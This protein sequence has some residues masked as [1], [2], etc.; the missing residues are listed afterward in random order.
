MLKRS[1]FREIRN[2]LGRYIAILAIIALGVGFFSGLQ[3]C[4]EAMVSTADDYIVEKNFFDYKVISTLGFEQSDVDAL[5][6]AEGIAV[7]EGSVTK[8]VLCHKLGE[9]DSVSVTHSIT[10]YINL[11][12]LSSGR[13][14]ETDDECVGDNRYY[15]E[16]DIGNKIIISDANDNDTTEAFKH[17]EYTLVGIVESPLYL[18]FQ[19]GSTSLGNGIVSGFLYFN[20]GGYDTDYY[21]EIYLKMNE[22]Y[23]VYSEKY[24]NLISSSE[25]AVKTAAEHQNETRYKKI[26][27]DARTELADG[28][29]EYADNYDRYLSEKSDALSRLSDSYEEIIN[30][31]K[32]LAAERSNLIRRQTALNKSKRSVEDGLAQTASQREALETA[33]SSG[34]IDD[35]T[36]QQNKAQ[37]DFSETSLKSSMHRIQYALSQIDTGFEQIAFSETELESGL[38]AYYRGKYEADERFAEVEAELS[39]AKRELEKAE[40]E[41]EDIKAPDTYVLNRGT[42]IGYASFESDS[43]IVAGIA[44]IF[45]VFFFLVAALVCMTTMTRMIDEQR[46]QIGVLKA[47][48]FKNASIIS[49]YLFYSGSAALIGWIVGFFGGCWLFPKVIWYA[50]GIMYDFN[51]SINYIFDITL[52]SL[53]LV[54]SLICSMGATA[55]SCYNEFREVPAQLIRPK[56][57]KNGK[58]IFLERMTFMWKRLSFLHKVTFRNVFRYKKRFFMMIAGICGCTALLVTGLGLRDSVKNIADFQYDEIHTYDYSLIFD[59]NMDDARRKDFTDESEPYI[60]TVKFVH[61]SSVDLVFSGETKSVNLIV[62]DSKDFGEFIHLHSDNKKAI[63]YPEKGETVIARKLSY[64][65]D[66]DVGDKI[67]LRDENMNEM[68]LTVSG[69]CENYIYNYVYVTPESCEEQWGYTPEIKSALVN[70]G[71]DDESSVYSSSAAVMQLDHVN[72]VSINNDMKNTVDNMMKSLDYVILL[73]LFSA[74]ALAFIVLYNLTNINITERIREIATIKVLGFNSKETSSYV[75]REIFLLTGISAV[76]GLVLGKFLHAFVMEQI[77]VDL[78]SFDIRITAFSYILSLALTFIFAVIVNLTMY[79]KLEK[80]SMTESLKSIE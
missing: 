76:V 1:T 11:L 47:L 59:R 4:K 75:F 42:N 50:Y 35:K 33:H 15:S 26:I 39:E 22:T 30:G 31:Q 6:N 37:L 29:K 68:E 64:M 60:D 38:S 23:P 36:Y 27:K 49:K 51:P 14:P 52:A 78:L 5:A 58:R 24:K 57:P 66:V 48:G 62:S 79:Y 12:N 70:A 77:Q 44:K 45:P 72:T 9:E 16:S 8:D 43:N 41:I 55:V 25:N 13:M 69:I 10:Q 32:T 56:S 3:I 53:S 61:Q 28:Q 18:N 7:A 19:R 2:S 65:Y 17:K 21:T 40:R 67:I 34:V 46:T 20:E 63:D 73:V 71:S 74:G 80:I 54:A